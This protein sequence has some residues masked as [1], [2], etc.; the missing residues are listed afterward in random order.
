MRKL[1]IFLV[2][3]ALVVVTNDLY[4]EYCVD[5]SLDK[6]YSYPAIIAMIIINVLYLRYLVK[7]I[8]NLLKLN[9]Q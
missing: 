4:A 2:V 5:R 3:T 9:K 7:S 1:F 6:M 8:I